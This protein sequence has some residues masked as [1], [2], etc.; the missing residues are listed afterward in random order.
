MLRI[1]LPLGLLLL[2]T[3]TTLAAREI[4]PD[5]LHLTI[6]PCTIDWTNQVDN[7][8]TTVRCA[9]HDHEIVYHRS[10]SGFAGPMCETRVLGHVVHSCGDGGSLLA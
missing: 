3:P 6:G 8:F 5:E 10:G 7:A 1:A 2:L 4:P 9:A